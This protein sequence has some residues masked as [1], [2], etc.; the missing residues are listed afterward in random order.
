[1][2][3]EGLT[4][5][6]A[7]LNAEWARLALAPPPGPGVWAPVLAGLPDLAAVLDAVRSRPDEVLGALLAAATAGDQL[8]GRVVVQAM[9]GKMVRLAVRDPTHDLG[10]HLLALWEVLRRY[11]LEARPT[12]IA[13]NLALDT[14]KRVRRWRAPEEGILDCETTSRLIRAPWR[15]STSIDEVLDAAVRLGM[16]DAAGRALLE[17]VY[18]DAPGPRPAATRQRCSRLIRRLRAHAPELALAAG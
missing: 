11:P 14:L 2:T 15:S 12:S 6:L 3:T 9:L 17:D 13:G 16:L 10:D 5:R 1:M 4:W 7:A 18:L 8:A